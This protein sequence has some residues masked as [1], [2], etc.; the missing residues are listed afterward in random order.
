MRLDPSSDLTIVGQIRVQLTL[1]IADGRVPPG[2]RLPAV[3]ALASSLDVNV[4]TVR[5]AYARLEEDGL[6]VTRHGVGTIAQSPSAGTLRSGGP[7]Y[8]SNSIGVLIAGLDPFY[9]DLL[10]GIEAVAAEQGTLVLVVDAQDWPVH[11]SAAIRQLAARGVQGIIAASLGAPEKGT[12]EGSLPPIVYVDQPDQKGE[13]LVFDAE[14]AGYDA[15]RHL[16]DH[17]HSRIGYVSPPVDWPNLGE[18]FD[19]HRRAL[20]EA[21]LGADATALSIVDGFDVAKGRRGLAQLMERGDPP[22]AVI[23]PSAMLAVGV[24]QEAR[25]AGL[26]VPDDLAIIGYADVDVASSIYPPL[27]MISLPTFDVGRAAM[28]ALQRMIAGELK[29]PERLVF[30]GTL[31]VRESCGPHPIDGRPKRI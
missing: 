11:A 18:L 29:K 13:S 17:G 3:R 24:L 27:T 10:R 28:S 2:T 8:L 6:V 5:A 4:N 23:T 21:G 16:L 26:D 9:L 7:R 19:G 25:Q 22:A 20:V 14:R 1:L 15:T 30:P 12:R 31:V